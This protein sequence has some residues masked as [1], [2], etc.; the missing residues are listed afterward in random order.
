MPRAPDCLLTDWHSLPPR[1]NLFATNVILSTV[2]FVYFP[3][4]KW[5][6]LVI[7]LFTLLG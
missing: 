7:N 6:G 1:Y 3:Y 5:V 2:S 4:D